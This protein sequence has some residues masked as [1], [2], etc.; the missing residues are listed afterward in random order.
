MVSQLSYRTKHSAVCIVNL[1]PLFIHFLDLDYLLKL[2]EMTMIS[3]L[4][5][6]S[7]RLCQ[8]FIFDCSSNSPFFFELFELFITFLPGISRLRT[9]KG[10]PATQSE[11]RYTLNKLGIV[12]PQEMSDRVFSEFDKG[13]IGSMNFEDFAFW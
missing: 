13:N 1:I 4:L 11:F 7:Y 9:A 3:F 8:L 2:L 12:L 10:G 6:S 5:L